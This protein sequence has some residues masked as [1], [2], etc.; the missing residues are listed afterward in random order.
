MATQANEDTGEDG[1]MGYGT[2][3]GRE[4]RP[5]IRPGAWESRTG[6]VPLVAIMIGSLALSACAT[7]GRGIGVLFSDL[8]EG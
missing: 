8:P 1:I 6:N 3:G 4:V 5:R 7:M 2:V